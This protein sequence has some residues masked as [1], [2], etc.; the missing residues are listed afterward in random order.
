MTQDDAQVVMVAA[1][2]SYGPDAKTEITVRV[3]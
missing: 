1:S 3:A 2:K